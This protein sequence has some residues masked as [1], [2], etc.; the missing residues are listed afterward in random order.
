MADRINQIRKRD[1]RI[2]P[3]DRSKIV[4]AIFKAAQAVGGEDRFIAEEL[5]S[6][7]TDYLNRHF[8]GDTPEIEDIQDM[9]E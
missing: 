4:D 6:A 1:G 9:V 2:M 5:A 8:E 7:V 3:F